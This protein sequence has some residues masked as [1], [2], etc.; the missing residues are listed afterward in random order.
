MK[1][2]PS[3]HALRNSH[4]LGS[5]HILS[6][7]TDLVLC[8]VPTYTWTRIS[9]VLMGEMKKYLILKIIFQQDPRM[10]TNSESNPGG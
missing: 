2:T 9:W 6:Q 7:E 10:K 8:D 4:R 1:V 5:G 3:I